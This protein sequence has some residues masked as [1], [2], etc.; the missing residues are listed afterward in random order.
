VAAAVYVLERVTQKM[1]VVL[2]LLLLGMLNCTYPV[3]VQAM[4]DLPS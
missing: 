3:Q 1:T 4:L 2:F